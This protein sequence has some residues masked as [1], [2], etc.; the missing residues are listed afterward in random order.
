MPLMLWH[1][2]QVWRFTLDTTGNWSLKADRDLMPD[3]ELRP[4][5]FE[6]SNINPNFLGK[7]YRC[8]PCHP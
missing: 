7:K 2:L 4:R 3:T 1:G 5:S 8:A 6:F